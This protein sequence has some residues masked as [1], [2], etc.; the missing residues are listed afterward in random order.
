MI[1][2]TAFIMTSQ[3]IRDIGLM[4]AAGC[5]NDLLFGYFFSEVV[6]VAFI[7][8]LF[9]T[10]LGV[11]IN[12]TSTSLVNG[13]GFSLSQQSINLWIPI[14]V[15][16]VFFVLS[17]VLGAAPILSAIRTEPAKAFS[18]S[19][20]FGLAKEPGFRIV[21]KTSIS[22][23]LAVRTLIRHR[24]GT[25]RVVL[26]L[27][28]VFFL[29]TVAVAGGLIAQGTTGSWVEGAVGRSTVLIANKDMVNQYQML[30]SEFYEGANNTQFDYA[31]RGYLIPTNLL[32][33]LHSLNVSID[34]R[35]IL[36]MPVREIEG[37]IYGSSTSQIQSVGDSRRGQSLV[38]GV[39]PNSVSNKWSLNG[40]FL[41]ENQ[42]GEAV[43]GDSLAQN[44]FSMPLDEEIGIS[45]RNFNL[46]GV[47]LDPLNNGNVTYV[48]LT[49]LQNMTGISGTNALMIT[50]D[51]SSNRTDT[52]N[53]LN[54]AIKA[55]NATDFEVLDLATVLNKSL[56]FLNFIWTTI[57]FLPLLSL[58][59]ASLSLLGYV[60]LTVNEQRQE[61]GVLRALGAKP[62]SV[63]AI[64]S[65]QNLIVLLA[66]YA[67]G[68][69]LGIIITLLILIQNPLVTPYTVFE[70]AGWLL[71]ALIVTFASSIYPAVTFARKPLLETMA[72]S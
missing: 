31:N 6:I 68:I 23:K 22:L 2:F 55:A 69:S 38:V 32:S 72:Q 66:S 44:L 11:V 28:I 63:L 13:L 4:K 41:Q 43:I 26:C 58:V 54:D 59:S 8:C 48:P 9:G 62:K 36:E 1:S 39:D 64:V 61:F 5:P 47:C 29:V 70:I 24:S 35:L 14:G 49:E 10:I 53:K 71:L 12:M 56:D 18:P 51:P 50:I 15:F 33:Q 3:R 34:A 57:M 46:I 30:L 25:I 19:Y 42:E 67:I 45:G 52:L 37:F 21:S 40:A 20:Y 7:G 65:A 17:L 16:I 27:S 60:T